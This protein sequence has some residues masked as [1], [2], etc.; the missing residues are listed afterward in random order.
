MPHTVTS[1]V[2]EMPEWLL[3]SCWLAFCLTSMVACSMPHSMVQEFRNSGHTFIGSLCCFKRNRKQKT[4]TFH[5]QDHKYDDSDDNM[6]STEPGDSSNNDLSDRSSLTDEMAQLS[7]SKGHRATK[8]VRMRLMSRSARRLLPHFDAPS[9]PRHSIPAI[10]PDRVRLTNKPI[11]RPLPCLNAP[12]G[13]DAPPGLVREWTEGEKVSQ[14]LQAL[15]LPAETGDSPSELVLNPESQLMPEGLGSAI[16]AAEVY[17]KGDT[18]SAAAEGAKGE[19]SRRG[20]SLYRSIQEEI[21]S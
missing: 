18:S 16:A 3:V 19:A 11:R 10:T 9:P 13:L 2:E 4:V 8:T 21:S 20:P 7:V 6:S 1:M 12:P 17:E 5:S 14:V 15:Q